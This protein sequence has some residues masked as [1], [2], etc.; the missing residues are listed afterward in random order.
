MLSS[1]LQSKCASQAVLSILLPLLIHRQ[2]RTGILQAGGEVKCQS[3][4]NVQV[5]KSRKRAQ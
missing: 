4:L 2:G 3:C 5:P 1:V